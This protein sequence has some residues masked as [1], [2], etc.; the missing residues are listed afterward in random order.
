M[1]GAHQRDDMVSKRA[2]K[3]IGQQRMQRPLGPADVEA[4]DDVGY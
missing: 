4:G 3:S 1:A 2:L